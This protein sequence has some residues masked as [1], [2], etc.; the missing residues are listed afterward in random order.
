[1]YPVRYGSLLARQLPSDTR[2]IK[3]N[4]Q[5]HRYTQFAHCIYEYFHHC[6]KC[7]SDS[8]YT[9]NSHWHIVFEKTNVSLTVC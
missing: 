7:L 3:D 6:F 9:Y 2:R 5:Y 4:F 1:M 8:N